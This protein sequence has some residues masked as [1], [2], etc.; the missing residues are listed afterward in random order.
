MFSRSLS[1]VTGILLFSLVAGTTASAQYG[2]ASGGT[3]GTGGMGSTGST[4]TSGYGSGSGKAIGIGVGVAA[5]AAAG[6]VLLVHHRHAASHSEASVV[7]CTQSVL[8]GISLKNERD[9]LTYTIL[10][11]GTALQPGERVELKGVVSDDKSGIH[12]FRVHNLVN[13]YGAC[14]SASGLS[15]KSTGERDAIAQKSN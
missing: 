2:G 7:G 8:N 3:G 1:R 13:N 9:S 14:E 15:A 11:G 5:G 4:S 10:P 12:A 6:I